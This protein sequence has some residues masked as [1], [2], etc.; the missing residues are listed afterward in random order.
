MRLG[1]YNALK[2]IRSGPPSSEI[3][4]LEDGNRSGKIEDFRGPSTP[5]PLGSCLET[6]QINIFRA[7]VLKS[8]QQYS[9]RS[10]SPNTIKIIDKQ[11]DIK[12]YSQNSYFFVETHF[13]S[14]IFNI[15][16]GSHLCFTCVYNYIRYVVN[17]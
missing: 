7:K 15:F 16:V 8:V 2:T 1:L 6:L 5:V 4:P 11:H 9:Y 13:F 10:F 3:R 12:L 14:R 17:F